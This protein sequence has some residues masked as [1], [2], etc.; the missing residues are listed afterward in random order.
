MADFV[1][2]AWVGG[3]LIAASGASGA[4]M[5]CGDDS[6]MATT[7]DASA[8]VS[9]AQSSSGDGSPPD[10]AASTPDAST[11]S[12]GDATAAATPDGATRDA[13]DGE[14]TVTPDGSV[15][16][17]GSS[18]P[19][20]GGAVT[21]ADGGAALACE[22][23]L[24]CCMDAGA[25]SNYPQCPQ[26][27]ASAQSCAYDG[28]YSPWPSTAPC[29]GQ[30]AIV[31]SETELTYLFV[32]DATSGDLLARVTDEMGDPDPYIPRSITCDATSDGFALSQAC[33]TQFLATPK[34]S[35]DSCI[36]AGS[37][38]YYCSAP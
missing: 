22:P 24:V 30:N 8:P 16:Q 9:D 20:A 18:G 37:P 29:D 12:V 32:Y 14:S 19:D 38:H 5:G 28:V 26:D 35:A 4:T 11:G 21:L 6:G 10:G 36:D 2:A 3:V 27:W 1:R 31:V 15:L 13:T 34:P 33:L 25:D 23:H 7:V 17:D